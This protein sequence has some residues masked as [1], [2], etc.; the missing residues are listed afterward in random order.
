MAAP[1]VPVGAYVTSGNSGTAATQATVTVDKPTGASDTSGHW[2]LAFVGYTGGTGIVFST[3]P[4]GFT[5]VARSD[6]GTIPG[7]TVFKKKIASGEGASWDWVFSAPH[8]FEWGCVIVE[9]ADQIDCIEAT[10]VSLGN[11]Q[12]QV[13]PSVTTLGTDRLLILGYRG[14]GA[15]TQPNYEPPAGF[16]E[17]FDTGHNATLRTNL[18]ACSDDQPAAGASGTKT[19]TCDATSTYASLT[20]AIKPSLGVPY[21]VGMLSA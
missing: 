6:N 21:S 7:L 19:A 20:L 1:F 14:T 8:S 15:A 5:Q 2:A 3:V 9:G 4:T 16:V 17:H 12:S 11:A 13:A 18:M 10:A